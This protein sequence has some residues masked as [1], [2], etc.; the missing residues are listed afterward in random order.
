MQ[1]RTRVEPPKLKP[2]ESVMDILGLKPEPLPRLEDAAADW[3]IPSLAQ[4][5][6]ELD[7]FQKV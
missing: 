6:M 7:P 4:R 5:I 3:V 2:R 1:R